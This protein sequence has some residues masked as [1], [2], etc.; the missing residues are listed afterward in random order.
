[1]RKE[2]RANCVRAKS[3]AVHDRLNE[4]VMEVLG[5][6]SKNPK[7]H[8]FFRYNAMLTIG[9]LN[10]VEGSSPT[11]LPQALPVLLEALDDAQQLDAVKIAAL[12]GIKRHVGAGVKDPNIAKAAL[13]LAA[14]T[15]GDVGKAWMR[16]Q[17]IELLGYLQSPGAN[18]QVVNLL[19]S[20]V[21]D[22]KAAMKYRCLAADALGQINLAGAPGVKADVLLTALTQMMKDGCDAEVKNATEKKEA[23]SKRQ[24]KAYLGSVVAA[25]GD[26]SKGVKS[27]KDP[28]TDKKITDLQK[29]LKDL[30]TVLDNDE[31][32]D[33]EVQKAVEEAQK[34]LAA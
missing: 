18:N 5:K 33:E 12:A 3:G 14:V 23:I 7:Y 11:P 16:A 27:L 24:T 17:A 29:T 6:K 25:L 28:A 26:A 20:L 22:K 4:L 15:D 10:T 30:L 9:E 1:M 8:P 32:T 21:A 13:K 31:S 2:L 19:Q 34:K